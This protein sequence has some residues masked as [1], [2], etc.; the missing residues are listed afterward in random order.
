MSLQVF[1]F[2]FSII[3]GAHENLKMPTVSSPGGKG[4]GAF[5]SLF[6]EGTYPMH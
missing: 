5:W 1:L 3:W 6:S 2:L 4:D